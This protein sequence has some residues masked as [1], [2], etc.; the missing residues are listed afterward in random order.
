MPILRGHHLVCLHFF[1]GEGYDEA[2]INNLE[3]TLRR[4]ED[5]DVEITEGADKVCAACLHLKE[6]RCMQSEGADKEI[7]GMDRKALELLGLSTGDKTGWK[8]LRSKVPE[9]FPE[10]YS[11]YCIDCDWRKM[12]NKNYLFMAAKKEQLTFALT[13]FLTYLLK[14]LLLIRP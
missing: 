13:C 14:K 3:D 8:A 9:I 10:W 2:F 6:G 1:D 4:A 7:R 12:C 5:A 11:L